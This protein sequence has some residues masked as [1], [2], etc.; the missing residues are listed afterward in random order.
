M[1]GMIEGFF[2]VLKSSIPGFFGYRVLA[3][4]FFGSLI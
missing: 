3:S 2:G 1:T 4:I